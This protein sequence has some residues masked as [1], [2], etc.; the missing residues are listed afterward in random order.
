LNV[1]RAVRITRAT[2]AHFVPTA[3]TVGTAAGGR[4]D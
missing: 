4:G 2:C 3:T 1:V